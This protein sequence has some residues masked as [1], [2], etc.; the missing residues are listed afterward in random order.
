MFMQLPNSPDELSLLQ[1]QAALTVFRSLQAERPTRLREF[2]QRLENLSDEI[3]RESATALREDDPQA[4]ERIIANRRAAAVIVICIAA[5]SISIGL[6]GYGAYLEAIPS[7]LFTCILVRWA[8]RTCPWTTRLELFLAQIKPPLQL[9]FG[10]SETE[11]ITFG[12]SLEFDRRKLQ[13]LKGLTGIGFTV[14]EQ[15]ALIVDLESSSICFW[16]TAGQFT[17][18]RIGVIGDTITRLLD[19]DDQF[20]QM[21]QHCF[22]M[23][24]LENLVVNFETAQSEAVA[25]VDP[26][27]PP[28]RTNYQRAFNWSKNE[29][30]QAFL[31]V[32]VSD[33][34]R[35]DLIRRL[36]RFVSGKMTG[37][38]GL[39]L[40]GPPGSGKTSVARVLCELARVTS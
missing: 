29:L 10:E 22:L 32:V 30:E 16:H 37:C 7:A 35:N 26:N 11:I 9:I 12:R 17:P 27:Q 28:P 20:H 15:W 23:N 39:L 8:C 31:Q 36:D 40:F 19:R 4:S 1:I 24:N 33:E 18:H 2:G 14:N 5:I 6:F 25:P 21:A 13:N 38:P 3:W 34:L